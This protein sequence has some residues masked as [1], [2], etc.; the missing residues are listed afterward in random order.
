MHTE[1]EQENKEK[2]EAFLKQEQEDVVGYVYKSDNM[3]NTF[4]PG[5][6]LY[7]VKRRFTKNGAIVVLRLQAGLL[8]C[9]GYRCEDYYFFMDDSNTVILRDENPDIVGEVI[10]FE[11]F[12]A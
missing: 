9:R 1:I 8:V 4:V 5:D 6:K 11:R 3:S 7:I 12:I 2:Q 10:G